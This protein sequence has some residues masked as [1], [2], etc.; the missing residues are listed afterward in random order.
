VLLHLK[1]LVGLVLEAALEV[2]L[3]HLYG[4]VLD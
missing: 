1:A 3:K 4:Q 2:T